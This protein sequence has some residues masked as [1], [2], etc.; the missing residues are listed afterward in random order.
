MTEQLLEA[1]VWDKNSA[2]RFSITAGQ[3]MPLNGFSRK[4]LSFENTE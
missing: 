3:L 4:K 2:L 1:A